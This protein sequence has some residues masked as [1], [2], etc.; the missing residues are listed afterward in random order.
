[1]VPVAH[2]ITGITF[3]FAFSMSYISIVRSLYCRI[4]SAAILVIFLFHEI[5]TS[6]NIHVHFPQ[7][8]DY[9]VQY[10]VRDGSVQIHVFISYYD[11]LIFTNSFC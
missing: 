11:Y 10:I 6:F 1:M 5:A 4:F 8:M 7:M 9:D 2:I 3:V